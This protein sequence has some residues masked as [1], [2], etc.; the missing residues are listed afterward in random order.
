MN[1]Q[2][3][4]PKILDPS[5]EKKDIQINLK[6]KMR[7]TKKNQTTIRKK[8]IPNINSQQ[9]QN[10][11]P[12]LKPRKTLQKPT[13]IISKKPNTSS[14][15]QNPNQNYQ[16]SNPNPNLFKKIDDTWLNKY[17]IY[18]HE[19]LNKYLFSPDFKRTLDNLPRNYQKQ[20]Y[21]YSRLK[22]QNN[23]VLPKNNDIE[24]K[25]INSNSNLNPEKL[26]KHFI[27]TGG[28]CDVVENLK[29]RGWVKEPNAKSLEFD[30]IWTL[31]TNEINFM[32]LKNNQLCNHYFRNGQITRKSGLCKNIKNLYYVG[33]DPNNFFPRCYDLSIK[34]ELEDFKQ[35]FKFTWAISLLK[36]IEKESQEISRIS[37]VSKK[38]ST[39]VVST[40]LNIVERNLKF[41][42]NKGQFIQKIN[43][44]KNDNNKSYLVSDEEW[45]IIYLPELTQSSNVQDIIY[46]VNSNKPGGVNNP[47]KGQN[48]TVPKKTIRKPNDTRKV[49]VNIQ[50]AQVGSTDTNKFSPNLKSIT[51][52][53]TKINQM[54]EEEKK[55]NS[56]I[57]QKLINLNDKLKINNN[58]RFN[59]TRI[60]D[61]AEFNLYIP[62]ISEFLSILEKNLPQYKL[63]GFR[64]IWI[65]K[66][67]NLSRGRGVTCV[68][69][70]Q[71]I[72]QSLTATNDSGLIV[73]K[74]IENPLIIS[75]R[76][77]DIR[78]WVLVTSLN[79]LTIYM[80][81]EP[82]IRFGAEDYIMDDLNNIYSHLTNN[83]IAKHSIQ[84]KK[85]TRFE[86]D[87]WK[88][89][90][91]RKYLGDEKLKLIHE[92][93]RN[94]IIC[95]FYA[96]HHEIKQR[97]NSHELYG[98]DF[99]IDEDFNVYLIEV[100]ASPALDYSTK[101][102]KELVKEMVKDLIYIV[103]DNNNGK[104]FKVDEKGEN[105]QNKFIQI[106]NETK[107]CIKIIENIPNKSSFY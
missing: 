15:N 37:K 2:L 101:I 17:F 47:I 8:S 87:M 30:Y 28:Y 3:Q 78:Q 18:R 16:I 43:E 79:P 67:S 65:M 102:T 31:K 11:P 46:E 68:D 26:K 14:K 54:N 77:F 42:E 73:Q 69:S 21:T 38:F 105:S 55:N 19:S 93:I 95:S 27:V 4:M 81:K 13:L 103:I 10:I 35:D 63:N 44:L 85:E 97:E 20:I 66:P 29:N 88:W 9:H 56:N 99:M 70:L 1:N 104:D 23:N 51:G 90:D 86:G 61:G 83:S 5:T 40:A 22:P 7:N 24:N 39:K 82:Y 71:P 59:N 98:Y 45:N 100:N 107:D 76:K 32:L 25:N 60:K 94:A 6:N 72:E 48:K 57:N 62:K 33:I 52:L 58:N 34:T 64:N 106:F 41:I 96:A 74:Y 36:L 92:K 50:S 75:K 84:Y 49:L 80:W 89:S 12:N 53:K 91:F